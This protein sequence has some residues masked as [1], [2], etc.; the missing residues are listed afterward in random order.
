MIVRS[1][2]SQLPTVIA[3]AEALDSPLYFEPSAQKKLVAMG[4][5]E[6]PTPAL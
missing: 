6:P 3:V 1:G 5:L 4:G 2:L